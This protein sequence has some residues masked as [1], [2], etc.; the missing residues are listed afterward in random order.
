MK[1]F[2]LSNYQFL[3]NHIEIETWIFMNR[4][5]VFDAKA[6]YAAVLCSSP[7]TL[8]SILEFGKAFP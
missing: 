3:E 7:Y 4:K 6:L 8:A 1:I 2:Q 5:W